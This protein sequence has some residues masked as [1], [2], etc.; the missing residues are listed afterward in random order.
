M[1][2]T[3]WRARIKR[4]EDGVKLGT[5]TKEDLQEYLS[6]K[7][8]QYTLNKTTDDNLWD[9]FKD[10][11]KDFDTA[12]FNRLTCTEIQGL[13]TYLRCGGV[14]VEQN[15]SRLTIAQSLVNVVQEET[16]H[17]WNDAD[18]T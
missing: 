17:I 18:I 13:R 8:Y 7:L 15:H 10:D 6:T 5:A 1:E 3:M 12:T 16:K 2:N 14:H 4:W 9:L 11:F